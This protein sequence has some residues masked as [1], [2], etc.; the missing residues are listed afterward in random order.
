MT[1]SDSA[2]SEKIAHPVDRIKSGIQDFSHRS[3]ML[4]RRWLASSFSLRVIIL[5]MMLGV[6]VVP[7]IVF[8]KWVERSAFEKE[9]SYVDENHLIIAKNLSAALSRYAIDL[10]SSFRFAVQNEAQADTIVGLSESLASF[11]ICRIM[12]LDSQNNLLNEIDG[13]PDHSEE[14]LA[15]GL[16]SYLRG[17]A[18]AAKGEVAISGI[19]NVGGSPHFFAAQMMADGRLAVAPWSPKYILEMQKSIAFGERGHSMVVDQDG[20]VVAHPNA[21]WQRISKDAS[22]LSVV[23]AMISRT[24]GVMQFYSPPLKAD[25]IAGYTF[26]PE[27]GWGVM[28]PQPIE[29]LQAKAQ[30]VQSAA[31]IIAA[32][33]IFLAVLV[34]LWLSSLLA[35]PLQSVVDAARRVSNGDT[36]ARV[37]RLPRRTPAEIRLLANGFDR[38]VR[39]LDQKSE[40]LAR[41]LARSEDVAQERAL[42]LIAANEANEVKSQFVSMV[43]H[44]LRTPLT[45]IKGSLD[46]LNSGAMGDMSKEITSLVSIAAKNASR[47]AIMINDLLDLE[48]LDSGEMRYEEAEFDLGPMLAES[49]EANVSFGEINGVTFNPI[50]L[51]QKAPVM[52]DYNRLMQVMANLLS[53]AAKFSG[54]GSVVDVEL[55]VTDSKARIMVR[56][57]GIGIPD[58]HKSKIFDKFVQID[59]SDGRKVGGSGLG[60]GIARVIVEKHGGTIDFSSK[61]GQGTTFFV[62]LP[63]L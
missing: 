35:R 7:I 38:M 47:L 21:E 44:E 15:P 58:S 24:T 22:K 13:L 42:L 29:E 25:M 28:V 27:T 63:L 32:A 46:L 61:V 40:A 45:S 1:A 33:E 14:F 37:G 16:L 50:N 55:V 18:V 6:S 17:I 23:K 30:S 9:I 12:I 49:I 3:K 5:A 34:S 52:G 53:N 57:S 8:Y 43:S 11:N 4:R 10:K 59:A 51:A 20:R 19:R 39:E 31:L 48:R 36:K 26:V 62:D 56:D 60:L 2:P 54:D 41:T